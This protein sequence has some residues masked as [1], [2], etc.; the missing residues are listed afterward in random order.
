MLILLQQQLEVLTKQKQELEQVHTQLLTLKNEAEKQ[1]REANEL[2]SQLR[3]G[4]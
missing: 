2:H 1:E 4:S 3:Q